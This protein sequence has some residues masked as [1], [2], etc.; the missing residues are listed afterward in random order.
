MTK[1]KS[2]TKK[3]QAKTVDEH[4]RRIL[5]AAAQ[6]KRNHCGPIKLETKPEPEGE[7]AAVN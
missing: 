4:G 2:S 3:K 6:A 7:D 1:K 5:T